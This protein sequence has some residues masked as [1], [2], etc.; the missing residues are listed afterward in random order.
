MNF[1]HFKNSNC[2][3]FSKIKDRSLDV[4]KSDA[5][6]LGSNEFIFLTDKK[7]VMYSYTNGTALESG[8]FKE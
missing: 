8:V 4:N 5:S 1:P 3:A 2:D 7:I 6:K